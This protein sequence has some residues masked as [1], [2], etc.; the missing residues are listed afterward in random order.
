MGRVS[1]LR[2]GIL[3]ERLG[4]PRSFRYGALILLPGYLSVCVC[5][6]LFSF[7]VW[8]LD[9]GGSF[10][11]VESGGGERGVSLRAL[12]AVVETSIWR[13]YA[14]RVYFWNT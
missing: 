8:S 13:M 10:D 7:L 4:S 11:G 1:G 3:K 9:K 12:R 6:F 5:V 2:R 14:V